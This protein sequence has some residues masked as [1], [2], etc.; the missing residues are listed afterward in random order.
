MK[1]N[2]SSS[3]VHL[4]FRQRRYDEAQSKSYLRDE[5]QK[6]MESFDAV[7]YTLQMQMTNKLEEIYWNPQLA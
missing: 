5:F 3:V 1:M 7:K 6:R 2:N 4:F